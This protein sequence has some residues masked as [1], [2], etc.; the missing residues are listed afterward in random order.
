VSASWTGAVAVTTMMILTFSAKPLQCQDLREPG[1]AQSVPRDSRFQ[2]GP[3]TLAPSIR[4][5]N[6]GF[7]DNVFAVNEAR[8]P[9]SDFTATLTPDVRG[10]LTL[11]RIR[12]G[13]QAGFE[14][15]YYKEIEG[16]RGV[17]ADSGVRA[18]VLL[19]YISPY[20]GGTF[21]NT[22]HGRN[23]E[24]DVPVRRRRTG[25]FTGANVRLT[26]KSSVDVRARRSATEYG[27]GTLSVENDP[28]DQLDYTSE[29]EGATMWYG[30]T[31]LTTIGVDVDRQRDR[32]ELTPERDTNQIRVAPVLEFRP[33]AVI[34]G[35][36]TYGMYK[37]EN[38]GRDLPAYRGTFLLAAL[39]YTLLGRTRFNVQADR[40]LE[41]SYRDRQQAYQYIGYNV[42]VTHRLADPWDVRATV[43][44]HRLTYVTGAG[45]FSPESEVRS[46]YGVGI[47]YRVG[48]SRIVVSVFHTDRQSEEFPI[49]EFQ[50]LRVVSSLLYAFD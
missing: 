18:D 11:P 21:S 37:R 39:R 17:N 1:Q 24:I 45:T 41:Y 12:V 4:L 29:G 33:D 19:R 43:D 48:R 6:F 28:T 15:V 2:Y 32:F 50:K 31:P 46:T 3:L 25:V 14:F 13:A 38:V 49:R 20:V 47:G 26:G 34:S 44:R 27:T 36:A 8:Q 22:R 23:Y 5:T 9:T 35:R 10:W 16:L 7:D 40:D 42:S 30:V